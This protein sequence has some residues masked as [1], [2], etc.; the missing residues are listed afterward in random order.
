[1][2]LMCRQQ[3]PSHPTTEKPTM[4]NLQN[5]ESV[6]AATIGSR[7]GKPVML[8]AVLVLAGCSV[9]CGCTGPR[10]APEIP[11]SRSTKVQPVPDP[12][13]PV[14]IVEIPKLLP[15]PGQMKPLPG[16]DGVAS[17]DSRAAE[18]S[19]ARGKQLING[20]NAAARV[21]PTQPGFL[22]A[23]QIWPYSPGALYQVYTSPG[24]VTDIA[25]EAGE[26]LRDISAPDTIRWVIGD[27]ESGDGATRTTH[28][29]VKPTRAGLQS[30]LTVYT[31]R[32]TYFLE[33]T[34]TAETWMASVSWEYPTDRLLALKGVNRDREA[35]API[36]DNVALEQLQFRY[37]ISGD[38]PSWRPERAFDDGRSVYI[39]FPAGIAQGE[40]PPLFVVGRQGE[41]QLINYR[42]KAPYYIVDRLFGAAELRLGG[43]K[44][45][46][47]RI[48]RT[49]IASA[50]RTRSQVP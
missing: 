23:I 42:V 49:D 1:M 3:T 27:T 39:Q 11:L 31:S 21:E 32:R 48:T 28:I 22:N 47:V 33:L 44:A 14:Q 20:A 18:S 17:G 40:M 19:V 9:L 43:E 15:L 5:V 35:A 36:A 6:C 8:I 41:S 29:A 2:R 45:Q 4:S 16:D 38:H 30:N 37:A 24:R 12:A 25:L 50:D 7:C 26:D 34:S 10:P 46:V 13:R